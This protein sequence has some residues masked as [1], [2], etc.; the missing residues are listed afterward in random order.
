MGH[1]YVLAAI[2]EGR[3]NEVVQEA[4]ILSGIPP[5][6]PKELPPDLSPFGDLEELPGLAG[7]ARVLYRK[8]FL[9]AMADRFLWL[10]VPGGPAQIPWRRGTIIRN[11]QP[12]REGHDTAH[13][14]DSGT[15]YQYAG[16]DHVPL[17]WDADAS[18]ALRELLEM[19]RFVTRKPINFCLLNYYELGDSIGAHSDDERDLIPDVGIFSVSLGYPRIFEMQSRSEAVRGA[20]LAL[21]LR[22]GSA[23]WMLGR[24]QKTHKHWIDAE[25]G[26]PLN[27]VV[28]YARVNLTFRAVNIRNT[29]H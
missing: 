15:A 13:F 23:L 26:K 7:G 11:G 12:C 27:N 25:K 24:T 9:G 6:M 18:G 28:A 1:V 17:G 8:N 22:H 5:L 14:G 20:A 10:F 29:T 16:K 3:L 2:L 19:V 21:R 4:A